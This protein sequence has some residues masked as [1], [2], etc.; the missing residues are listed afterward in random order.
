M[1]ESIIHKCSRIALAVITGIATLLTGVT[2]ASA[3]DN[4]NEKN[5]GSTPDTFSYHDGKG[6]TLPGY[7]FLP[8]EDT[9]HGVSNGAGHNSALGP[10]N[11]DLA[12]PAYCIQ[13]GVPLGATDGNWVPET[14]HEW[15]IAAKLVKDHLNDMSD[16]TQASVN[17]ALHEH[18]DFSTTPQGWRIWNSYRMSPLKNADINVIAANAQTMW[19]QAR[20]V[21][22]ASNSLDNHYY[23]IA[24]T[25]GYVR[26]GIWNDQNQFIAGIPYTITLTNAVFDA[27]GQSSINGVTAG[28]GYNTYSWHSTGTGP[29]NYT[30]HYQIPQGAGLYPNTQHLMKYYTEYDPKLPGNLVTFRVNRPF[31]PTVT[32]QVSNKEIPH[33]TPIKD[34][35]TSGVDP[36]AGPWIT[37][38]NRLTVKADGY[39]FAG[40]ASKILNKIPQNTDESPDAYLARVKYILGNPVATG[41]VT[42]DDANQTK[43]VTAKNPDGSDF[44]NPEDYKFGGWL[45]IIKKTDQTPDTQDGIVGDYVDSFGKVPESSVHQHT[46]TAWS[47]VAEPH[48]QKGSDVRDVIHLKGFPK[49]FGSFN[50][51]PGDYGFSA[52]NPD[53]E[54]KVYWSGYDYGQPSSEDDDKAYKPSTPSAPADDAHHKLV[55]TVHYNLSDL[56]RSEGKNYDNTLDIKVAG[57]DSGSPLS[58][59][60]HFS[61]P[62]DG[63]GYYTFVASYAGC[64]R[65]AGFSTPYNDQFESTFVTTTKSTVSLTSN[66]NPNE[67]RVFEDF[68]D[69]ATIVGDNSVTSGAYVSF[70]AYNPVQGNPDPSAGKLLDN[71]V[72][73]LTDDQLAELHRGKQVSVDSTHIQTPNG[74]RVYWQAALHAA[75]GT[76]LATHPLGISSETTKIVGSGKISS[77]AQT[78]GAVGGDAWDIITV[79]DVPSG[80]KRGNIPAGSYVEVGLY[81]HEGQTDATHG[82]KVATKTYPVDISKLGTRP[83]SYSFKAV[84]GQYPAAGRYNWTH[85]LKAPDGTVLDEG[86]YGEDTERTAVQEYKT[87]S[88]KKWLSTNDAD[89]S[90]KTIKTYDVLTQSYYNH[91]GND[92]ESQPLGGQTVEGTQAQFT[93]YHK[94]SHGTLGDD[95]QAIVTGNKFDLPKVPNAK[96]GGEN[97]QKLKSETFTLPA[98]APTGSYYYG[99]RVTNSVDAK[100][101]KDLV[102]EDGDGLVYEAPND[103][104]SERFEVTRVTSKSAETAW[105]DDQKG[106]QENLTVDGYLPEGSSYQVDVQQYDDSG[107]PRG[108]IASTGKVKF[109]KASD[110]WDTPN[111]FKVVMDMPKDIK[112]GTY[113]FRHKIWS[114]DNTGSDPDIS[115]QAGVMVPNNWN[116]SPD[117]S[118]K[119]KEDSLMYEGDNV[120]SERFEIIH[121]HTKVSDTEGIHNYKDG[122]YIDVTDMK[123]VHDHLMIDGNIPAGYMVKFNL[124][125]Q[126]KGDAKDDVIAGVV[127]KISVPAGT[128]DLISGPVSV[129]D[130]GR[131]Y[132]EAALSKADN[133]PWEPDGIMESKTPIRDKEETFQAVTI[134]TSTAPWTAKGNELTDTLIVSGYLPPETKVTSTLNDET[135]PTNTPQTVVST[136]A[137]MG[138]KGDE[139]GTTVQNVTSKPVTIKDAHDYY[140]TDAERIPDDDADFHTGSVKVEMESTRSIDAVTR[141]FVEINKDSKVSDFTSFENVKYDVVKSDRRTKLK[142]SWELWK[143]GSG[144]VSTDTKKTVANPDGLPLSDGQKY[145]K[146]DAVTADE[147]GIFYWRVRVTDETGALVK[148]GAPREESESFRVISASSHTQSATN[149]DAPIKDTVTI[150]GPVVEGTM[151]SWKAYKVAPEGDIEIA[152]FDKP[153][154]GAVLITKEQA[155][156]AQKTGKVSV[157]TPKTVSGKAKD[158]IY[159]V[160]SV[161][162]PQ[163]NADGSTKMP[164]K[165]S[166]GNFTT[167]HLVPTNTPDYDKI[168]E[169]TNGSKG[170]GD[171]LPTKDITNPQGTSAAGL[172]P[173]FTDRTRVPDETTNVIKIVTETADTSVI[174]STVTDTA[175]ITGNIPKG[176]CITFEYWK[177]NDKGDRLEVKPDCLAVPEGST[178]IK[179]EPIK[180]DVAGMHYFRERLTP[181][182]NHDLTIAY[183]DARLPNES[184]NITVPKLAKTGAG[185]LSVAALMGSVVFAGLLLV[186]SRRKGKHL[187]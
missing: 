51:N 72:H 155:E 21:T 92:M 96:D 153:S 172:L 100:N 30:I 161:T 73:V 33:N 181:S 66:T 61:I 62:A 166:D 184:V 5:S 136:L 23:S 134:S 125:K 58:D 178:T 88:A 89:Y 31:Q 139:S 46:P 38:D 83:G 119:Y 169:E 63:T 7:A 84:V 39:Y 173:I 13:S 47:E 159:W 174:H 22:P 27:N 151:V 74:G 99:L 150:N 183:G 9:A 75:D 101:L 11:A 37:E 2:V 78:Q 15:N 71:D 168:M 170:I 111:N 28:D 25:H 69:T 176:Y 77:T 32:T 175:K 137:E 163:R 20:A 179:S 108:I 156:E 14:S 135:V 116:A 60:S 29:A 3:N 97:F 115:E 56:I 129:S 103:V 50:G 122:H 82:Q 171:N 186:L 165:G 131:Y 6:N 45:W 185:L 18:L 87:D 132:W 144:D 141:T 123:S 85:V 54:V 64:A 143:Q 76:V 105:T 53:L 138:Y 152:N 130:F 17:W 107:N 121:L 16:A 113:Q 167:D 109:D 4:D 160:F 79:S 149:E 90:Q 81:K 154:N 102:G 187:A 19:E 12:H 59:G 86:K 44:M 48:A 40:D 114:P 118:A 140:W 126:G 34:K 43:E 1:K 158:T 26:A 49:D 70:D 24:E 147:L 146:S 104:P 112:P 182:D 10:H 91:W 94:G 120:P 67:V 36:S 157:T 117:A 80:N 35:I 110:K 65:V 145:A 42:F 52:D 57:G 180:A 142:A 93:V 41:S 8:F 55:K 177:Q 148:Y 106:I 98:D 128:K 95:H 162:S 127:P 124:Y 164:V 133:T 68:W